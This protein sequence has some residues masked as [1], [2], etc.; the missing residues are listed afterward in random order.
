[1]TPP[2]TSPPAGDL[3]PGA[4]EAR[5]L[6]VVSHELRT[7]LTTIASFT[8]SM[9]ADEDMAPAERSLALSAVRR[10]TDRMLTL[11]EDLMLLSRLQ[12]GDLELTLTPVDPAG[13]VRAAADALAKHEP[14]TAATLD[15]PAGPPVRGDAALLHLLAYAM[16]GTVAAGAADR[17]ATVHAEA[18]GAGWTVTVSAVQAEQLTDELLMAGTLALPEPPHRR[19]STALWMLLATAIAT[20]HGGQVDLTYDP[21]VGAG[22]VAFLPYTPVPD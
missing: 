20:R 12:T 10:N 15:L 7:P 4:M 2:A 6:A 3:R 22:A 9:A 17:S 11:V 16:V 13:I 1:M 21:A 18:G 8:E 14:H 19:R 5:F